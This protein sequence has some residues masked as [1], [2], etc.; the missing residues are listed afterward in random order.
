[1]EACAHGGQVVLHQSAFQ[2]LDRSQLPTNL[3]VLFLGKHLV[4]S[5]ETSQHRRSSRGNT[6]LTSGQ[7]V[8]QTACLAMQAHRNGASVHALHT[9]PCTVQ[10]VHHKQLPEC[11]LTRTLQKQHGMNAWVLPC[12]YCAPCS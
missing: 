9:K 4:R 8:S 10:R 6:I 2:L 1:M 3:S 12:T 5:K 7:D 11:V